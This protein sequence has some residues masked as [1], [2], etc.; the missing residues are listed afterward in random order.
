MDVSPVGLTRGQ[1]VV[2]GAVAIVASAGTAAA[3]TIIVANP[4]TI[5]PAAGTLS[6]SPDLTV[7]SQSLTYSGT[8]ATGLDV[9]VNNT[10]TSSH[11]VDLHFVLEDSTGTVIENATKT[12]VSIAGGSTSTV[13]WTFNS[14]HAVDTF[15]RVEVTVE[16]TG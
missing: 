12:G 15:S 4:N 9:V 13:S 8:D 10:G 2:L 6:G 5:A 7:D 3:V 11:T 14:A 1:L 16:V